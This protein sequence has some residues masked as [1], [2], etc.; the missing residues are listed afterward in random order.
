[1]TAILAWELRAA[2]DPTTRVGNYYNRTPRSWRATLS[3]EI[4]GDPFLNIDC[5]RHP[6]LARLR[7][8]LLP[9]DVN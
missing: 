8:L 1:M 5:Y 6:G 9:S 7:R 2:P 3:C 4:G